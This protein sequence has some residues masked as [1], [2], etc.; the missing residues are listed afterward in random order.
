[1]IPIPKLVFAAASAAM[2]TVAAPTGEEAAHARHKNF[3]KLGD[4]F[5]NLEK[6]AKKNKPDVAVI[7]RETA[8]VVA[9]GEQSPA[10]FP[11]GSGPGNGFKT[12]ALAEVWTQPDEFKALQEKFLAAVAKLNQTVAAGEMSAVAA[13]VEHTGEACGAC[14]KKFRKQSSL[15]SIFGGD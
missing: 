9:L 14:H 8:Q 4:A 10:W 13:E 6:Q 5:E 3:E 2:L 12:K 1:M 7:Q 11:L 15:F